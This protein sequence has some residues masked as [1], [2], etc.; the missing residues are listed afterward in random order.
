M[1]QDLHN[2]ATPCLICPYIRRAAAVFHLPG[3]HPPWRP[4]IC[5]ALPLSAKAKPDTHV[6]IIAS[7]YL[8]D[9]CKKMQTLLGL[10]VFLFFASQLEAA[11][12][13]AAYY[14]KDSSIRLPNTIGE[15]FSIGKIPP[16]LLTDLYF[17]SLHFNTGST[18]N[19]TLELMPE[20]NNK[21]I[22]LDMRELKN[23]SRGLNLFMSIGGSTFNDPKSFEGIE[24]YKRISVMASSK[25]F[26]TKF[27]E[28]VI[29]Y[30]YQNEF[31][32]IDLDWEYPG[33]LTRGGK[34]EDLDNFLL[35]LQEFQARLTSAQPKL[36]LS[37]AFPPVVPSGLPKHF[38]DNPDV[39]FKWIASCSSYLDRVNIMAYSYHD[40]YEGPKITGVNAP[41]NR[42][43]DLKSP[44]YIAKT[45]ENYLYYG[46]PKDKI[47][48]GIPLFGHT[49][50]GVSELT[51]ES[52][53]PGKTFLGGG[54]FGIPARVPGQLAY[55]TIA[56]LVETKLFQYAPDTFT[57]TAIAYSPKNQE[58]ISYDT[59]ETVKLKADLAV[60]NG[61]RGIFFWSIDKDEYIKTPLFPSISA[62]KSAF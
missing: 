2:P 11:P 8:E 7:N 43:T 54:L 62:G 4:L 6:I 32:G 20:F 40:P 17:A 53:Q 55:H 49:Y 10:L 34:A 48:L 31:D 28:L 47:I 52:F 3:L 14:D 38:H 26:R 13:I 12:V 33:D 29:N 46:V 37:A 27:I 39:Y 56:N 59:P 35:L 9:Y 61:L 30:A 24:S 58:W 1:R 45:I 42:D 18:L 15:L 57:N 36:L 50:R 25:A 22:F 51:E 44:L 60:K 16:D 23:K 5:R 41:L 19:P 21:K